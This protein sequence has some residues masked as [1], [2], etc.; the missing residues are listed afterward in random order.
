[1]FKEQEKKR[2]EKD[3]YY[4]RTTAEKLEKHALNFLLVQLARFFVKTLNFY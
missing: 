4:E 1:M 3:D 2:K